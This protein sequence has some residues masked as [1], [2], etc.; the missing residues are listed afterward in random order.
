[1]RPLDFQGLI[2][3]Y[4]MGFYLWR[5]VSGS[6]FSVVV[7]HGTIPSLLPSL[8]SAH[9]HHVTTVC[10]TGLLF[11]ERGQQ[12]PGF[13]STFSPTKPRLSCNIGH[14]NTEKVQQLEVFTMSVNSQYIVKLTL[15]FLGGGGVFSFQ[16]KW[17]LFYPEQTQMNRRL[18][19]AAWMK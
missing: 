3:E 10:L 18:T 8:R 11:D 14:L 7:A 16:R 9:Q 5:A 4:F 13:F 2:T 6:L 12:M 19:D 1:M 15:F 17:C